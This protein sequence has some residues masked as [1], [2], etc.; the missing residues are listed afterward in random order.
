MGKRGPSKTPTK[1]LKMR[2]SPLAKHRVDEPQADGKAPSCPRWISNRAKGAFK[3]L[4]P[5]IKAMGILG[6]CDRDALTRYCVL[7][8][9]YREAE[10]FIEERGPVYIVRDDSGK[11]LDVKE[12]PQARRALAL[13]DRLL[14]LEREFGLTP[15]ARSVMAKPRE[16][17]YE[18]RG[19]DKGRF[20]KVG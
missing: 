12:F 4:V 19:K 7:L 3:R 15:S 11:V 13:A 14:K 8:A 17:P 5:K 10:E 2:G 9:R 1:I 16:N 6:R 18:N 20:F